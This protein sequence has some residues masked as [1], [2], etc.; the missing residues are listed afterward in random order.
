MISPAASDVTSTSPAPLIATVLASPSDGVNTIPAAPF[1]ASATPD[2]SYVLAS[3][4]VSSIAFFKLAVISAR[5]APVVTAARA[6]AAVVAVDSVK[7]TVVS[8]ADP[9]KAYGSSP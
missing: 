8:E 1:V 2:N 6:S 4:A 7:S 9:P 3:L 5:L